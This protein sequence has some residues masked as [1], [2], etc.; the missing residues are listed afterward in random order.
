MGKPREE[1]DVA[2]V[3]PATRLE[4]PTALFDSEG[5]LLNAD[6]AIGEITGRNTADRF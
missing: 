2:V 6:E 5:R 3:D 1:M 4:C